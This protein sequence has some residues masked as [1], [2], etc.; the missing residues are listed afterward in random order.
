MTREREREESGSSSSATSNEQLAT[1]RW[2]VAGGT[3]LPVPSSCLAGCLVLAFLALRSS[4]SNSLTPV[5]LVRIIKLLLALLLCFFFFP[6]SSLPTLRSSITSTALPTE[7]HL[8]PSLL[9]TG[10]STRCLL[11]HCIIQGIPLPRCRY[12]WFLV[13]CPPSLHCPISLDKHHS[14]LREK[15]LEFWNK[16]D[17]RHIGPTVKQQRGTYCAGFVQQASTVLSC[18]SCRFRAK[19]FSK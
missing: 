3:Q 17:L 2:Q 18:Y 10:K 9:S 5:T 12:S 14:R 11:I 8:T 15:K 1:G 4:Q 19:A 6:R 13:V 16:I 7:T